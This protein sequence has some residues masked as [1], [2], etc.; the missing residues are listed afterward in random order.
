M[1]KYTLNN[2]E[3]NKTPIGKILILLLDS[4]AKAQKK[5]FCIFTCLLIKEKGLISSKKYKTEHK[6]SG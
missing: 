5:A 6:D 1:Q 4:K 3:T 2:T